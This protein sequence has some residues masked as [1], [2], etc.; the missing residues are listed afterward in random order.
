MDQQDFLKIAIPLVAVPVGGVLLF[1]HHFSDHNHAKR[2]LLFKSLDECMT[3][4]ENIQK[5]TDLNI[6]NDWSLY[7]NLV[8]CSQ[9]IEYSMTGFPQN[10]P[11]LFQ[12]TLGK[13]IFNQFEHQGYMRH[14]RSEPI[15]GATFIESNG[16]TNAAVERLK[17]AVTDFEHFDKELKPHFAYGKLSKAQFAQAHCMHVADHFAIM[18][19]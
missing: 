14:N 17:K 1:K 16:A 4:L 15:P 13:L 2:L 19:Y 10:K 3:E 9:S 11:P 12:K 7:Q 8:H 5:A 18:T 6:F